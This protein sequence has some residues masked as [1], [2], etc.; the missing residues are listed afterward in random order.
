MEAALIARIGADLTDLKA[1]MDQ[2]GG[3]LGGF[4]NHVSKLGPAIAGAFSV[5]A[6]VAFGKAAVTAAAE[7]IDGENR[8]LTALQG[9]RDIQARLLEQANQ[10]HETTLFEDDEIVKQQGL[11]AAMGRSEAQ[12]KRLIEASVQLAAATGSD[13]GAAVEALNKTYEGQEKSLKALDPTLHGFTQTQLTSGEVIDLV[14]QKYEGFAEALTKEGSGGVIMAEKQ[15]NDLMEDLGREILPTVNSLLAG[16]VATIKMLK[17]DDLDA[18]QKFRIFLNPA[19]A[20]AIAGETTA[21]K[22]A[23]TTW[24]SDKDEKVAPPTRPTY[25]QLKRKGPKTDEVDNWNPE[26]W[27]DVSHIE[28]FTQMKNIMVEINKSMNDERI[29]SDREYTELL[30]EEKEKQMAIEQDAASAREAMN[31]KAANSFAG[32]ISSSINGQRDFASAMAQSTKQIVSQ[33]ASQAIAAAIA[34]TFTS[35]SF[36][37]DPFTTILSAGLITGAVSALFNSIGSGSSGGGG[38]FSGGSAASAARRENSALYGPSSQTVKVEGKAI[39]SG[40]QLEVIFGRQGE[41]N[42]Y[43]QPAFVPIG[44]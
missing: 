27:A 31:E 39:I 41:Y 2:A 35:S 21:G 7:A 42:S 19:N 40:T 11:L 17:T 16:T 15:F 18:W 9:R 37:K 32:M 13:L 44:G 29:E 26:V 24:G 12:I 4:Q 22:G 10:L 43:T 33:F 38:S 30:A 23:Q 14:R 28:D 8:L 6:I 1:K 3:I 34:R 36:L 25:G 20:A 5:T